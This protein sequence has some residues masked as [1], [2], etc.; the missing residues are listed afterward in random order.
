MKLGLRNRVVVEVAE[1]VAA[2]MP[3]AVGRAEEGAA[4]AAIA[5]DL[6]S[7]TLAIR[8]RVTGDGSVLGRVFVRAVYRVVHL[9]Q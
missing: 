5:S 1:A 7:T 2:V 8:V 3:V 6:L 9:L 4:A